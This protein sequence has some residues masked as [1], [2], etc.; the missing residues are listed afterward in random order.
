MFVSLQ[1]IYLFVCLFTDL[2][3]PHTGA[4]SQHSIPETTDPTE[5]HILLYSFPRGAAVSQDH[6]AGLL[7]LLHPLSDAA[8]IPEQSV[9]RFQKG[10]LSEPSVYRSVYAGN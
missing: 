3:T 9:P 2:F 5:C 1:F 4:L 8:V 6:E 7:L 10:E